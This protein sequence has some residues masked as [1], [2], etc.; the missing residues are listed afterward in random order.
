MEF[1]VGKMELNCKNDAFISSVT[2]SDAERDSGRPNEDN[3]LKTAELLGEHGFVRMVNVFNPKMLSNLDSHYRNR[4]SSYLHNTNRPNRRPL[5]TVDVEGPFNDSEFFAH[6][7][8][9]PVIKKMLGDNSILAALSSV[10][11][12]PG[13][14]DQYIHRDA[15][16]L[17]GKD[18][19]VDKDIP[20]YSITV[21]IPLVDC[22]LQT[23]CTKVW[24]GS[25]LCGCE[26]DALKEPPIDPEV[27]RGSI[28][29]TDGRLVHRGGANVSELLR[30]LVYMTYHCHWYRDFG[31]YEDRPPVNITT[32]E[33]KKIPDNYKHMFSWT[34]DP[35]RMIRFKNLLRRAIPGSAIKLMRSLK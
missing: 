22:N 8:I 31:G 7:L 16:Q 19:S 15:K 4:Y 1:K 3:I 23:G 30:P 14:P 11:S 10:V 26:E 2:F 21:L 33:F 29:M 27:Q 34:R 6:P 9:I 12:F 18:Y 35:Y 13:A 25:H 28:L 24:P 17:F 20:A 32:K 5:F